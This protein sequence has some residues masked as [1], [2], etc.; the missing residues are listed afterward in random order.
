MARTKGFGMFAKRVAVGAAI[1]VAAGAAAESAWAGAG[2][3]IG[4]YEGKITCSG[5]D[6]GAPLKEKTTVT[7][8]NPVLVSDVSAALVIRFP[9]FGPFIVFVEDSVQKPGQSL[10]GGINCPFSLALS[11]AATVLLTAKVKGDHVTLKGTLQV[12]NDAENAIVSCNFSLKRV[13]AAD[14]ITAC[15]E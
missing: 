4:T 6:D 2:G 12:L 15:P 3:L 7:A 9:G 8:E 13:D 1:V 10:V 5:L 14:P 11:P